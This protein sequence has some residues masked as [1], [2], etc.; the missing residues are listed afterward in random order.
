[1]SNINDLRKPFLSTVGKPLAAKCYHSE[2]LMFAAGKLEVIQRLG[3][4]GIGRLGIGLL[5]RKKRVLSLIFHYRL[6]Y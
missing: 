5:M 3:E 2:T 6:N 1:M 4:E